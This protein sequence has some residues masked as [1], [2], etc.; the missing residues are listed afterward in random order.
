VDNR[1]G[2][3]R[4]VR[5]RPVRPPAVGGRC[6]D[7]AAAA[8][9]DP[10]LLELPEL[11]LSDPEDPLPDELDSLLPDEPFSLLAVAVLVEPLRLSVR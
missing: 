7:A 9:L 4:P 11:L 8:A 1:P 10:L 5:R 6:Q 2:C 3:G